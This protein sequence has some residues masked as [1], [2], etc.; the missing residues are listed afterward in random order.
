M[1]SVYRYT[2]AKTTL[3]ICSLIHEN[4]FL[5]ELISKELYNIDS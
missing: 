2:Q 4:S 3:L 5:S 1:S